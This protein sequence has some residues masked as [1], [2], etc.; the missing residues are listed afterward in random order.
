MLTLL[1]AQMR[2]DAEPHF[3]KIKAKVL[4]VLVSSDRLYPPAL[5]RDVMSKLKAAGVDATY[6]LL[7]SAFGHDATTPDAAKWSPALEEFHA[8]IGGSV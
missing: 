2:F 8:R 3:K 5:A 1:R 6:F 7:E 4:Y